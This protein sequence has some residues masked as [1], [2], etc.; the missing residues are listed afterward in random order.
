VARA[1]EVD[2][3]PACS[4]AVAGSATDT[5]RNVEMRTPP[6]WRQVPCM[7]VEAAIGALSIRHT[8]L[9]RDSY[10]SVAQQHVV[11]LMV[12]VEVLM[13]SAVRTKE[14]EPRLKLLDK[15]GDFEF[16]KVGINRLYSHAWG[17][18]RDNQ[19][20]IQNGVLE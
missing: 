5:V 14:A 3:D 4:T 6:I 15:E 18:C 8:Q 1:R 2:T 19:P 9:T 13:H 10:R 17:G 7:A 11:C 20:A 16:R 12:L